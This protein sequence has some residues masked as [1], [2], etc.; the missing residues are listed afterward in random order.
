MKN[1][2]NQKKIIYKKS[3]NDSV[4]AGRINRDTPYKAAMHMQYKHKTDISHL[5]YHVCRI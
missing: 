5:Y 3:R 1:K 4:A 2:K